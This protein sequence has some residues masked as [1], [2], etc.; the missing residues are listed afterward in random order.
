MNHYEQ[1]YAALSKKVVQDD[2][3]KARYLERNRAN[4]TRSNH[5]SGNALIRDSKYL[6]AYNGRSRRLFARIVFDEMEQLIGSLS[7]GTVM[8][9]TLTPG[10]FAFGENDTKHFDPAPFQRLISRYFGGFNLLGVIEPG[11]YPRHLYAGSKG[12][13]SFHLHGIA[14]KASPLAWR[15]A[16]QAFKKRYPSLLVNRPSAYVQTVPVADVPRVLGYQYKVPDVG[17][18]VFSLKMEAV[19]LT[20]GEAFC[21]LS[22]R[23]KSQKRALRPGERIRIDNCLGSLT[24]D[25][26]LIATGVE[27]KAIKKRIVDEAL[28]GNRNTLF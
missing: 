20:T 15:I 5:P 27:G 18:E 12:V 4:G 26:L 16:A 28:R 3:R 25:K 23:S 9:I 17:Y 22:E 21:W 7:G 1:E 19:D 8:Q 13:V 2:D 24:F 6:Y 11:F 14:W 10:Q